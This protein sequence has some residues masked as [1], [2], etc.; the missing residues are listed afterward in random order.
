MLRLPVTAGPGLAGELVQ[1]LV[2][3]VP[4]PSPAAAGSV[5]GDGAT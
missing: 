3:L 2:E 1:A 5:A 4:D